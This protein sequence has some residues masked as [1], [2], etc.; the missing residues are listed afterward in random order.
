MNFNNQRPMQPKTILGSKPIG[1]QPKTLVTEEPKTAFERLEILFNYLDYGA[2]IV[3]KTDEN[4]V[5]QLIVSIPLNENENTNLETLFDENQADKYSEE[6]LKKNFL[7]HLMFTNDILK[8]VEKISTEIDT[9]NTFILNFSS[10]LDLEVKNEKHWEFLHLLNEFNRSIPIGNFL[11]D[12]DDKLCFKYAITLPERDIKNEVAVE[13]IQ[14]IS[15]F[16]SRV[17]N[18][19]VPFMEGTKTLEEVLT[20]LSKVA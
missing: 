6:F 16:V 10:Y 19:C 2:F 14:M 7:V 13:I 18:V 9:N 1:S 20:D 4:P 15:F 12:E 11:I 17:F 5:E 3:P 8:Q